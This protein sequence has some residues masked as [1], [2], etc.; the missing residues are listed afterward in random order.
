[1][2]DVEAFGDYV[3][4]AFRWVVVAEGMIDGPLNVIVLENFSFDSSGGM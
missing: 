3:N 2:N 1:M 4:C